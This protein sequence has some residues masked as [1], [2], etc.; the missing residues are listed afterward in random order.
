MALRSVVAVLLCLLHA[1]RAKCL[2]GDACF[3]TTA[4]LDRLASKLD[5]ALLTSDSAAWD[6]AT[7]LKNARLN[8][9][10]AFV[11][12]ANS[13]ADI[14]AAVEFTAEF[15]L[16]FSVKSTGHCYNGNCMAT[17]SLHLDMRSLGAL[18]IEEDAG[19]GGRVARCGPAVTFERLYAAC[20][21]AGALAVGGMGATV[22]LVGYSSGGGHGPLVRSFGL[23]ADQL[24]ALTV[25][26]ANGSVVVA[27][28]DS[29]PDL[30]W[31]FRGGGGG[32][33]GVVVEVVVALRDAPPSTFALSCY[34]P[35]TVAG[36][37]GRGAAAAAIDVGAPVRAR[38]ALRHGATSS[39]VVTRVG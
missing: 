15:D 35:M 24:R 34:Y 22:G 19:G 4:D 31:A 7:T 26:M 27:T 17:G 28:A 30:F 23:G 21:A 37:D 32:A 9:A 16:L 1:A 10:P 2:P 13:T 12:V 14:V 38:G 8:P 11:V 6:E 20:D 36:D 3:P 18:A 25:V 29:A 33:W 39:A 5:G